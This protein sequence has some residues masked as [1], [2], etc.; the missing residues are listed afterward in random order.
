MGYWNL[1]LRYIQKYLTPA[2]P[3]PN[4]LIPEASS[5]KYLGTIIRSDLKWADHVNY[6]LRNAWKTLH[7]IKRAPKKGND[8]KK[9]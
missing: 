9:V 4:Q 7:F 3:V 5:F 6:T 1:F 2:L 8:N